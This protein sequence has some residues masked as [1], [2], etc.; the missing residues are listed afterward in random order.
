MRELTRVEFTLR[1]QNG[2]KHDQICQVS[3]KP[4]TEQCQ[5]SCDAGTYPAPYRNHFTK[6]E[7]CVSELRHG[8][9][10]S[11]ID[12]MCQHRH[13]FLL[14][15]APYRLAHDTRT[16]T[17]TEVAWFEFAGEMSALRLP[18]GII[19]RM[20]WI[21]TQQKAKNGKNR[22]C[23]LSSSPC[24]PASPRHRILVTALQCV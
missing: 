13:A 17:V 12:V 3:A 18:A 6:R 24:A 8:V 9:K 2:G 4:R 11:G 1:G 10:S 22:S 21:L 19:Q 15:N 20:Q 14:P 7:A 5:E 16:A 23:H